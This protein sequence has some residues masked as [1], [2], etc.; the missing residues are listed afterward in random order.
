M[1]NWSSKELSDIL[2]E[3]VKDSDSL[4]LILSCVNSIPQRLARIDFCVYKLKNLYFLAFPGL[5]PD[6]ISDLLFES[7]IGA[8]TEEQKRV[9]LNLQLEANI[10]VDSLIQSLHMCTELFAN[11]INLALELN[12]KRKP[13]I[14]CIQNQLIEP[15]HEELRF[16][17]T[18]LI[19]SKEYKYIDAYTN[20]NKHNHLIKIKSTSNPIDHIEIK[21]FSR[22]SQNKGK[23]EYAAIYLSDLLNNITPLI[24]S[25]IINIGIALNE[26]AVNNK[27]M[28][29]GFQPPHN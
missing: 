7:N 18:Q 5:E 15:R 3:N 25:Q 4:E 29:D 20:E 11:L 17:I 27:L 2:K 6:E 16:Q 26:A 10:F 8:S 23:E 12:V 1:M 22:L 24:K 28:R 21:P 19:D 14:K 9:I 13:Y